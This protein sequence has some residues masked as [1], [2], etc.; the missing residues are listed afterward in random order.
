MTERIIDIGEALEDRR[1]GGFH[2]LVFGLCLLIVFVDGLDYSAANVAAPAIIRQL[3]AGTGAMAIVFS[4]GFA[5]ILAGSIGF[6]WIGDRYGRKT[7]ALL[8]VLAYSIPALLTVFAASIDQ[9]AW[10]RAAAGLGIGGVIPNI[11]A[12]LTETAPKR[13]RV[14]SVMAV[15]IGYSLGNAAI[16][17]AAAVLI[18]A[19]GWQA[20]FVTAGIAGLALFAALVFALPESIPFLAASDPDSRRL[21]TLM[22][23]AAPELAIDEHT[24]FTYRR[25]K[26][27]TQ[28]SLALLFDDVRR[29]ATPIVW[30]AFF[31]ESLTYMTLSAW[32]LVL[33]ERSG[34]QPAQASLAYV[35]GQLGAIALT[36][37][38]ARLF[39][40]SGPIASTLSAA[41]AAAAITAIGLPGLSPAG[42]TAIGA[43]AL[44]SA[45]AT[46]QSL[47]GMVGGFYPTVIRGNGIGYATGMGRAAAIIGPLIA[48]NMLT[49]LP[50]QTVLMYIA[51]P[52]LIVAL[53]CLGL[54]RFASAQWR[55]AKPAKPAHS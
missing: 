1:L 36:L 17:Q 47:N 30:I 54:A 22:Q 19:H 20:V 32:L 25:P 34:L 10:Y 48:G 11:I 31:A 6:G 26:K 4:M 53:C 28:F 14:T 50:P 15:F 24:R 7:G 38:V 44:A 13:F 40:H 33:L 42:I 3:D 51:A 16:S 39:D 49:T 21:R 8:G 35:W 23:R 52:D 45:S 29:I 46:H 18:P 5:G 2:W 37:T 41:A 12:L 43:L 55:I 9:L 27:E